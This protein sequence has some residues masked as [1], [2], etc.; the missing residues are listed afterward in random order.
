MIDYDYRYA[1]SRLFCFS[2]VLTSGVKNDKIYVAIKG[3]VFDVTRN[4]DSY[5]PD[6]GYHVFVG[7]D[8]SRALAMS[9]LE[10][11]D[12]VP[13]Y[14]DLPEADLKVLDDWYTFFKLRY[15][16]VGSVRRSDLPDN[17]L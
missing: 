13:K 17:S 14:K 16:I 15:N 11:E 12:A 8:A 5:G 1:R 3:T 10:P 7:K 4:K 6:G 2:F 9:S